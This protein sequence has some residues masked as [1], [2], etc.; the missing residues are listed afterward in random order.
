MITAKNITL[1]FLILVM[2]MALAQGQNQSYTE[3]AN[4][5]DLEMIFI[6]GGEF[7]TGSHEDEP[8]RYSDDSREDLIKVTVGDFY[9]SK[10]EVTYEQFMKID[11][12]YEPSALSGC[13]TLCPVGYIAW[14]DAIRFCNYLSEEAGLPMYYSDDEYGNIAV[15]DSADGYRLPTEAEW[16]YAAKGGAKGSLDY[17]NLRDSLAWH[18][19]NAYNVHPVGQKMPNEF[20]LYDIFG[21][22]WEWCIDIHYDNNYSRHTTYRIVK[23]GAYK[24]SPEFCRPAASTAF[25]ETFRAPVFGIRVVRNIPQK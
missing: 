17:I 18:K 20:G 1:A 12:G 22:Q 14:W 9:I 2:A 13:D 24:A 10:F 23:G 4:G 6:E 15:D 3:V 11:S 8:G 7:V 21:N 5:I 16:E 19:Y 25:I